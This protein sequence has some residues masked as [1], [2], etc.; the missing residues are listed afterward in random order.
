MSGEPESTVLV[1]DDEQGIVEGHAASLDG[2]Y[3]VRTALDGHE[4]IEQLDADVDVVLLDRRMPELSGEE[5]LA[6]I[7]ERDLDCRVAMLTGVEPDVDIVEMGF[8]D[9]VRKPVGRSE[10]FDVVERLLQRARYDRRLQEFF[11]LASKAAALEAE[12]DTAELEGHPEYER[13]RDRLDQFRGKLDETVADL[14]PE[15]RYAV[16]TGSAV[17][18]AV[19]D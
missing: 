5:V 19:S 16:A 2:E 18:D 12:H 9:Y 1:V 14:P 7:R 13:L 11:S 10:L 6:H 15:D 3:A 4:A 8:D 17:G